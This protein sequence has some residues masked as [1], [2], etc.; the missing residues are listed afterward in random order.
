[1]VVVALTVSPKEN[2]F[3]F[4]IPPKADEAVVVAADPNVGTGV[5][6]VT[7]ANPENAPAAA[8]GLLTGG[9][10]A[11]LP[12]NE[13]MEAPAVEVG[14]EVDT[15]AAAPKLN[16]GLEGAPRA[17]A[18]KAVVAEG[19]RAGVG[20][21]DGVLPKAKLVEMGLLLLAAAAGADIVGM[22]K[23]GVAVAVAV[24]FGA[25]KEKVAVGTGILLGCDGFEEGMVEVAA[26]RLVVVVAA[27]AGGD[28]EKENIPGIDDLGASM[29]TAE[30]VEVPLVVLSVGE[31]EAPNLK[32]VEE[33]AI[34]KV[35]LVVAGG[36][37]SVFVLLNVNMAVVGKLN[38]GPAEIEVEV[39]A[40]TG[41]VATFSSAVGC[42][43]RG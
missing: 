29:G 8:A 35:A 25:P 38:P 11:A 22:A 13:N 39:T 30:A 31:S 23:A 1:M 17:G 19:S 42:A 5:D 24:G 16:A 9:A 36:V 6:D 28:L 3:A 33:G 14:A 18:V 10:A 12:P 4:E 20:S 43:I 21:L 40:A 26:A 2:V 27:I 37:E 41:F 15:A 32:P 34:D 7:A